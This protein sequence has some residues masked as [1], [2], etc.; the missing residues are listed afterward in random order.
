MCLSLLLFIS[1]LVTTMS[2]WN[3]RRN[4]MLIDILE[5]WWYK[6][7][8]GVVILYTYTRHGAQC[9]VT[10]SHSTCCGYC[11]R[12]Y[13]ISFRLFALSNPSVPTLCL[14]DPRRG[15]WHNSAGSSSNGQVIE[16]AR[17]FSNSKNRENTLFNNNKKSF[18]LK[19]VCETIN[20]KQCLLSWQTDEER[21][22]REEEYSTTVH[23]S[24]EVLQHLGLANVTICRKTITHYP[25]SLSLYIYSREEKESKLD[26]WRSISHQR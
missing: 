5:W 16:V 14:K 4:T 25:R 8:F 2:N 18:L 1:V 21:I 9:G 26:G 7:L 12:D 13:H 20:S 17:L 22:S 6:C 24:T 3:V 23:L 15:G 19:H 10:T 11:V